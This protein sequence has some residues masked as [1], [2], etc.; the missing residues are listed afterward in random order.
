MREEWH[1]AKR[2]SIVRSASSEP[3]GILATNDGARAKMLQE[4]LRRNEALKSKPSKGLNLST[5]R[6][7]IERLEQYKQR[8]WEEEREI[9]DLISSRRRNI[10]HEVEN[11]FCESLHYL[12]VRRICKESRCQTSSRPPKI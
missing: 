2:Q 11:F 7:S 6:K 9:K 10:A 12:V 4:Q 3:R 8:Q 5:F 1:H